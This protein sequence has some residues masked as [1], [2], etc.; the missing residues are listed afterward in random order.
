MLFTKSV[1]LHTCM[2][3]DYTST[4]IRGVRYNG[5]RLL[6]LAVGLIFMHRGNHTRQ[7]AMTSTSAIA[8]DATT[9]TAT[10]G[11]IANIY[12]GMGQTA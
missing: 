3:C 12:I 6:P 8:M 7:R 4:L 2:S 9:S 1:G 11:C 5:M 10:E